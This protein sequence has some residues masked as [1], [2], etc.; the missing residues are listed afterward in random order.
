MVG[1]VV[2]DLGPEGLVPS[3]SNV[4]AIPTYQWVLAALLQDHWPLEGLG[5]RLPSGENEV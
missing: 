3:H 1:S 4:T 2:S 5:V